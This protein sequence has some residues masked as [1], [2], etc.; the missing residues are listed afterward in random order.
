MGPPLFATLFASSAVK[1]IFGSAPLRVYAFGTAPAKGET[2]Y[3]VPY[4]VF[5]TI[6]GSPENYLN[7]AP[8][9][10]AW[11]VQIDVYAAETSPGNGLANARTGAKAIR[12]AVEAVA[13]VA[14]FNGEGK[15]EATG[16]FRYSF[17]VSF[18]T[19]R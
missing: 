10:D 5:Q 4:A 9:L 18:Q 15:D 7:E 2:G 13:Y 19:N 1:A 8:D 11:R 17:D 12:N 14:S 3:S 6:T 16:L